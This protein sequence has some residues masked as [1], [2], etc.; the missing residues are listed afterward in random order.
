MK[1]PNVHS[2]TSSAITVTVDA[3]DTSG[4]YFRSRVNLA[5]L[6]NSS[7]SICL[8]T[9]L[10][11]QEYY[12]Y[13]FLNVTDQYSLKTV[14]FHPVHCHRWPAVISRHPP[15][16]DQQA[17]THCSPA[18]VQMCDPLTKCPTDQLRLDTG[19]P[20][21]SSESSFTNLELIVHAH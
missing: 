6:K 19:G 11:L 20:L 16:V 9:L 7:V 8:V 10:W 17:H 1:T 12:Q 18:G 14:S 3:T 5:S 15:C 2:P 4:L 21:Y 13:P